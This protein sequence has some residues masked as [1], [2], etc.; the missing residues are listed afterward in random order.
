MK[1]ES[2]VIREDFL[3]NLQVTYA[4]QVDSIDKVYG[5]FYKYGNL[6][7]SEVDMTK[8]F[9]VRLGGANF[10][11]AVE[12]V[13]SLNT[14]QAG[15]A[16]RFKS[17]RDEI[18]ILENGVLFLISDAEAVEELNTLSAEQFEYFMPKSAGA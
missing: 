18:Y 2:I 17:A 10:S 9:K 4:G 6:V 1:N 16:A 3:K 5:K 8:P 15:L 14:V 7:E 13:T 12:A 11:E